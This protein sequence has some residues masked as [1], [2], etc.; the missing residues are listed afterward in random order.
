MKCDVIAEVEALHDGALAPLEETRV[1]AH[2]TECSD[3]LDALHS[4]EALHALVRTTQMPTPSRS[5]DHNVARSF[6]QHHGTARR[7]A[8]WLIGSVSVPRWVLVAA[9]V[10]IIAVLGGMNVWINGRMSAPPRVERVQV[11]VYVDRV[12]TRTVYVERNGDNALH[13]V[14]SRT[15]HRRASHSGVNLTAR[16]AAMSNSFVTRANLAGFEPPA[17]ITPRIFRET[18]NE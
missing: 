7:T 10:A 5:L 11:P 15:A 17:E 9:A 4:L 13:P 16:V 3:C 14:K 8:S 2:L 18:N 12:V 6:E 1:R